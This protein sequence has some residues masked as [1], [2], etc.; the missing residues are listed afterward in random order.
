MNAPESNP[1]AYPMR[2]PSLSSAPAREAARSAAKRHARGED[3]GSSRRSA[4][5]SAREASG[6]AGVTLGLDVLASAVELMG[7]GRGDVAG[8]ACQ[9]AQGGQRAVRV[10]DDAVEDRLVVVV[11]RRRAVDVE[12]LAE[13]L[14]RAQRVPS[15]R[16]QA[17]QL[18]DALVD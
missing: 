3:H 5:N 14:E 6:G 13:V 2:N 9:R 11:G 4:S 15:E 10:G 17:A 12:E 7:L 1:C 18:R 8:L 16:R